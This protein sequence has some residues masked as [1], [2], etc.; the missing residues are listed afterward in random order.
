[1]LLTAAVAVSVNSSAAILRNDVNSTIRL[2]YGIDTSILKVFGAQ[3]CVEFDPND[4]EHADSPN[5]N[6]RNPTGTKGFNVYKEVVTSSMQADEY[7]H[8]SVSASLNYFAASGKFNADD[9]QVYKMS[10]DQ[11]AIGIK[12][13]A[14]YGRWY[15]KHVRLKP[16]M[17][18][19]AKLDKQAFF[20]KCGHEYVNGYKLGQGLSVLLTTLNRTSFYSQEFSSSTS[21]SIGGSSV[22]VAASA[23][24]ESAAKELIKLGKVQV[25][26]TGYGTTALPSETL[27]SE[28]D[29]I[30]FSKKIR[31]IV[32][33]MRTQDAQEISYITSP[34]PNV[35]YTADPIMEEIKHNTF[36]S[37]FSDFRRV[38][39]DLDHLRS[40]ARSSVPAQISGLCQQRGI[41]ECTDYG[42]YLDHLIQ[43]DQQAIDTID[44]QAMACEKAE[45]AG[46]CVS[47]SVWVIHPELADVASGV[48]WPSYYRRLL[49]QAGLDARGKVPR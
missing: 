42:N 16:M 25:R 19:L 43:L 36:E 47:T 32:E 9:K 2:G 5:S 4:V 38:S 37:L 18:W 11:L 24:F 34:Y 8:T 7:T 26:V 13:E 31:D 12:A 10:S 28:E 45:H 15:L 41:K 44:Q 30:T 39:S 40:I 49:Y 35:S 27:S 3:P 17:Y 33:K 46:D 21:V 29:I 6:V 48:K 14:D 22:G 1:M 20:A 23:A